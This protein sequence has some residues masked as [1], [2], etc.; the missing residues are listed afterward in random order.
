MSKEA[1]ISID[2]TELTEAQSMAVRMAVG[3]QLMDL[4]NDE[5][6]RELGDIAAPNQGRL[7]EVQTIILRTLQA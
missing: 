3:S 1:K 6:R 4:A 5:H 2:G 7:S